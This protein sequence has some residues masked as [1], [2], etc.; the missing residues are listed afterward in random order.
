MQVLPQTGIKLARSMKVRFS[1]AQLFN[2][3]YNLQL[4]THYLAQLLEMYGEPEEAVAAYNAGETRV[5]QWT[6][7]GAGK[8]T[9]SR[10]NL[11]S[12]YHSRKREIMC[13]SSCATLSFTAEYM[14]ICRQPP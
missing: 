7:G 5:D 4:G 3:E 2:P 13:R 14:A 12:P 11:W 6:T 8:F 10:R 1:R 9:K